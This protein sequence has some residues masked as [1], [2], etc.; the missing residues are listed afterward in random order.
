MD[1]EWLSEYSKGMGHEIYRTDLSFKFQGKTF[2]EVAAIV[3]NEFQGI[4]FGIEFDVEKHTI[5]RLNPGSYKI[6]NPI[7]TNVHAYIICEDKK[8][9]D[10]V[11]TYEMTTEEIANYHVYV[12]QKQKQR[13]KIVDE[14]EGK[15]DE[16]LIYGKDTQDEADIQEA[17]YEILP[18]PVSLMSV[19]HIN[20]KD[21]TEITNHIVVCGIHPSIYYF[22]LPLRA[23]YLKEIQYIVIL[24][25]E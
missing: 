10:L 16:P 6:Q 21:S 8:V 5:I 19:T 14:D 25:P 18:Y 20:I 13:E 1:S 15:F 7:E 12:V 3:Y 22:L 17:D 2:S 4:L 23:K 11:A 24:A 9:A